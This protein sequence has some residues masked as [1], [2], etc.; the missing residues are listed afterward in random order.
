MDVQCKTEFCKISNCHNVKSPIASINMQKIGNNAL[1]KQQK[2]LFKIFKLYFMSC[3]PLSSNRSTPLSSVSHCL[4][5]LLSSLLQNILVNRWGRLADL[6][7]KS[8]SLSFAVHRKR[9]CSVSAESFKGRHLYGESGWGY[10]RKE[11]NRVKPMQKKQT[12]T[13]K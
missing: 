1:K 10:S 3:R 8:F 2:T 13:K 11:V 7:L 9:N 5:N 12:K 4:S 6:N